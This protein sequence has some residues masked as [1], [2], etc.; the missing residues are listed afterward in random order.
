VWSGF[1]LWAFSS[2]KI[3]QEA[4]RKKKKILNS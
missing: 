3:F 2:A 1:L 4:K